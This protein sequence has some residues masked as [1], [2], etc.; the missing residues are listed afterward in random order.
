MQH[1]FVKALIGGN[2]PFNFLES[3]Q[4]KDFFDK[5]GILF[6]LPSRKEASGGILN[7]V[8]K[9]S[10]E[11]IDKILQQ[12]R[13]VALVP[14]GWQ[15]VRGV[16]VV[17]IMACNPNVC[18]YVRSFETGSSSQDT[19]L[20]KDE[21][22]KS[23]ED[24]QK[25]GDD[26]VVAIV[27]DQ[28]SGYKQ[29]RDKIQQESGEKILSVTCSAHLLNLLTG[30]FC[31]LSSVRNTIMNAK[32]VVKEI[33]GSKLKIG[34]Y[35]DEYCK[36]IDE[37]KLKG[38]THRRISLSLPAVT[39]WFGVRDMLEKLLRAKPVLERMSINP[40][41]RLTYEIKQLIKSDGFWEKT[42]LIYLVIEKLTDGEF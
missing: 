29:A 42:K 31:K 30:D 21:L 28:G 18:T 25:H 36:W 11:Q 1:L 32:K 39:R 35:D 17:N 14:D 2:V 7:A 20:I 16:A 12:E 41:S 27:S 5:L 40:Q 13:H 34:E 24:L 37:E 8:A 26:K 22:Q 3:P 10:K 15:N 9:E 38:R 19:K 4:L 33:R 6:V 23:I